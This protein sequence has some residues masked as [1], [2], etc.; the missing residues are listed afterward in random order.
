MIILFVI[1]NNLNNKSNL[2]ENES[3]YS[4]EINLKIYRDGLE[5]EA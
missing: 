5:F 1:A 4:N 2:N 3:R